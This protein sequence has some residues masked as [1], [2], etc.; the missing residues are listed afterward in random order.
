MKPLLPT[1]TTMK[2]A[3]FILIIAGCALSAW[4]GWQLSRR[5]TAA[6]STA[7]GDAGTTVAGTG[8]PAN[9]HAFHSAAYAALT[10][11]APDFRRDRTAAEILAQAAAERSRPAL[12]NCG[13]LIALLW[14]LRPDEIPDALDALRKLPPPVPAELYAAVLGRMAETD[15]PGA[16]READKLPAPMRDEA[17]IAVISSW[18]KHDPRSAWKWYLEAWAAAPEPRYQMERCFL[19]LIHAWAVQDPKAALEASLAEEE[20]GTLNPWAGFGSVC[21]LPERRDEVLTLLSGITDEKKRHAALGSALGVWSSSQPAA[22]AAWLDDHPDAADDNLTWSVAERY[23]YADHAAATE[24]L[25]NRGPTEKREESAN[26]MGL[27]QW[28]HADPAAAGEWLKARPHGDTS[29]ATMASAW[30]VTDLD[31]ALEWA[32]EMSPEKR[33]EAVAQVYA[34]AQSH[35]KKPD[36]ARC[37]AT[38][39]IPPEELEKIAEKFSSRL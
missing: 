7:P 24:W 34:S 28:A 8:K 6:D 12:Q 35:G 36:L 11:S 39:G 16:M 33:P 38:A 17:R 21:A 29:R 25:W 26:N 18:A 32:A 5:A 13:E 31:R 30:A 3:P 15:A 27:I 10:E 4:S 9:G 37:A 1:S 19:P 23:G 2:P 14:Q 22:A 20:H